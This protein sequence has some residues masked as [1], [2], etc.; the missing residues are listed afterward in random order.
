ML[1]KTRRPELKEFDHNWPMLICK[2][3]RLEFCAMPSREVWDSKRPCAFF[4]H[5]IEQKSVA[6]HPQTDVNSS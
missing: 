3:K 4:P 5:A 2:G 1:R 6:S